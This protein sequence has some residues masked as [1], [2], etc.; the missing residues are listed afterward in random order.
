MNADSKQ[1]LERPCHTKTYGKFF[2][3]K[4][5]KK[6]N[7]LCLLY[8]HNMYEKEIYYCLVMFHAWKKIIML[9]LELVYKFHFFFLLL[10]YL[11]FIV[12]LFLHDI[13]FLNI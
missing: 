12:Y 11:Y 13:Y 6:K 9:Y 5:G 10:L 4:V 8:S 7:I 2:Q 3:G 1:E